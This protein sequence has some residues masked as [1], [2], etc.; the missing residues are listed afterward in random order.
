MEK[1]YIF[2]SVFAVVAL[3]L[4]VLAAYS[5]R[6]MR[7]EVLAVAAHQD[8]I[9]A[10]SDTL[11]IAYANVDSALAQA[12]EALRKATKQNRRRIVA[13]EDSLSQERDVDLESPRYQ[14]EAALEAQRRARRTQW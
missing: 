9:T 7:R 13:L 2:L 5:G 8:S 4:A 10:K 1:P 11:I 14:M 12:I 3:L 6:Q